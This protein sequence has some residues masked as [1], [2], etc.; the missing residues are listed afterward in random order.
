MAF[1]FAMLFLLIMLGSLTFKIC[2]SDECHIS[3]RQV[4]FNQDF[5]D[6]NVQCVGRVRVAGCRNRS[7]SGRRSIDSMNG[8]QNISEFASWCCIWQAE[9]VP[10]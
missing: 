7:A 9:H 5:V 8:R 1:R 10:F 2:Q 6:P 4:V 3:D